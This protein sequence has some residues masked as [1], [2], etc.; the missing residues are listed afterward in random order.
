MNN[1]QYKQIRCLTDNK[2]IPTRVELQDTML[3]VTEIMER[4]A[5]TGRWWKQESEKMF[6]RIQLEDGSVFE[7]FKDLVGSDWFQ[8]KKYD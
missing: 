8:Y 6:Y 4:W 3:K 7:I 2:G 5:D 1:I